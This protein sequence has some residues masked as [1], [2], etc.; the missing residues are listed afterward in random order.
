MVRIW[1]GA[2]WLPVLAAFGL[3]TGCAAKDGRRQERDGAEEA[4]AS[5]P[6]V[7]VWGPVVEVT[8]E[9]LCM[10]N[11]SESG[12][13]GELVLTVTAESEASEAQGEELQR[14]DLEGAETQKTDLEEKETQ[15]TDLEE[16]EMQRGDRKE[17]ETQRGDRK[18][19]ETQR[20][21]L[22]EGEMQEA[23]EQEEPEEPE[24]GAAG[25][26]AITRIVDAATG[27]PAKLSSLEAGMGIFAYLDPVVMLSEPPISRA[28]LI[29]CNIPSDL[30]VPDYVM[31]EELEEQENGGY[32]LNV[33]G[34]M[35]YRIPAECE[36][37][38]YLT[39]NRVMASDIGAG[40]RCL[41]WSDEK[42]EAEKI[43]LFPD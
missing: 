41:I 15:K 35:Q 28:E 19:E 4:S 26:R 40:S 2:V 9:G 25:E 31:A 7:R 20:T 17:A 29:L 30:R 39:K 5:A 1:K 11:R 3:L 10:D 16:A 6:W 24:E 21:D 18:G 36:I 23:E 38:P 33:A 42:R 32:I 14:T 8:E 27:F 22:E 34:E 43:I 12:G 13:Q 37:L